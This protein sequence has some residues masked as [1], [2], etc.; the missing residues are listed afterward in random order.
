MRVW[1]DVSMISDDAVMQVVTDFAGECIAA[2]P[3]PQQERVS[4]MWC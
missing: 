3:L 2:T 1:L 4:E